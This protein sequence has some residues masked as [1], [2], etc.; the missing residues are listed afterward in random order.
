MEEVYNLEFPSWCTEFSISGYVFRRVEEYRERVLSLQHL[1]YASHEF[2]FEPNI[3][4]HT[5]TAYV[6]R[7]D[8][9]AQAVLP[10][11]GAERQS[12][13]QDVLLLLSMFTGRDVFVRSAGTHDFYT[14]VYQDSR[15]YPGGHLLRISM[16]YK[17]STRNIDGIFCPYDIGFEQ[18]LN[19]VYQLIRSEHWQ[20]RYA[21]GA[22]LFLARDA[23]RS[24]GLESQFV[25]CWTIWEHVFV[26]HNL[27][28]LGREDI[29]RMAAREKIAFVLVEYGFAEQVARHPQLTDLA[30]IRNR[31]VHFGRFPD[32]ADRFSLISQVLL[33]INLTEFLVARILGLSPSNVLNTQEK[34][35][36]FLATGKVPE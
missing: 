27:A 15:V 5:I 6:E 35:D 7:L 11:G 28:W 10:W 22:L 20:R 18:G 30:K 21:N 33:F 36:A 26:L 25:Q 1:I 12:A 14:A 9:E 34:W 3:G 29:E 8:K 4:G 19:T 13:L 23:F 17:A 31:L 2:S 32:T 24:H 16:P